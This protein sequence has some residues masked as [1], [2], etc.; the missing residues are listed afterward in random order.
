MCLLA[1]DL[2]TSTMRRSRFVFGLS[3]HI[4]KI[5]GK[6]EQYRQTFRDGRRDKSKNFEMRDI[7]PETPWFDAVVHKISARHSS[8][9]LLASPS[10][11]L[12]SR[13]L[14]YGSARGNGRQ[15]RTV[16]QTVYHLI[17]TCHITP[18]FLS[19]GP[20]E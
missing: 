1:C 14:A 16:Y 19:H 9:L 4:K 2:E 5:Q 6:N 7:C 13:V 11:V 3:R 10:P 17:K 15:S 8:F 20:T 12:L 18:Q